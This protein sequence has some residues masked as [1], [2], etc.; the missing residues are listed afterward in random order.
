MKTP[1]ILLS[2]IL[3][4]SITSCCEK[5]TE[6]NLDLVATPVFSPGP[7][8]FNPGV[9]VAISCATPGADIR[10]TTSGQ[11]THA[12]SLTYTGPIT[13]DS[14][15]TIKAV[16]YYR[17]HH[18]E[19]ATATFVIYQ[20]S[21]SEYQFLTHMS[22]TPDTIFADNGL[23]SSTVSVKVVDAMAFGIPGQLVEFHTTLGHIREGAV[24]DSTGIVRAVLTADNVSGIARVTAI[25]RKYHAEYPDFVISADTATVDVT[26]QSPPPEPVS[27]HSLRFTQSGQ[28]DLNVMNTGGMEAAYLRVK[29]Y[30]SDGNLFTEPRNVWFRILNPGASGGANLNNQSPADSVMAVSNNGIAQVLLYSGTANGNIVVKASCTDNGRYRETVKDNI[31]VHAGPAYRIEVFGGGYNTGENMG[32]GM[33]RIVVGAR[34]Y[35]LYDNPVSYGTSVWFQIIDNEYNCQIG[36]AAYIGNNSVYGDNDEGTAYTY[37]IYSGVYSGL[38]VTIRASSGGYNGQE[39]Y[40]EATI[41]LPLN[42]PQVEMEIVPGVLVFHGNTNP[43]PESATA[44]IRVTCFDIQGNTI[45]YTSY[46]LTANYGDFEYTEGSNT[47][48]QYFNPPETPNIILGGIS[49]YAEGLIRFYAADIPPDDPMDN[50]PSVLVVTITCNLMGTD[51]ITSGYYYLIKY[52]T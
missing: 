16:A 38:P 32:G 37:L 13:V 52:A 50:H 8:M 5:T 39:V 24:T 10:Y 17:T 18:S 31:V 9:Q 42:Q 22:A 2:I 36:A 20:N 47:D 51:F 28:I 6:V 30:D 44:I 12:G 3:L 29:L 15:M 45:H 11:Y 40:G 7:Y 19:I 43:V 4:L 23:T 27:V 14:T 1:I 35:D 33:W 26:I 41:I 49:N 48:P 46:F 34:C 21:L 25:T